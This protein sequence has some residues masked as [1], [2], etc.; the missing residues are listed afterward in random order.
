MKQHYLIGLA[1]GLFLVSMTGVAGATIITEVEAN[2]TLATAQN[3]DSFFS[4]ESNTDIFNSTINPWVSINATGDGSYD[5]FSFTVAAGVTG[6]FDIDRGMNST[7]TEIALWDFNGV[8]LEERDDRSDYQSWT[9]PGTVHH[10]DPSISYTFDTAGTY[11]IGV[12]EFYSRALSGGW[13]GNVLDSGDTYT[14]QVSLTSHDMDPVP[15][16][17]TMLLFGTGLLGLVGYNRKRF[18]KKN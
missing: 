14:L 17:A 11:V 7:D 6:Y 4:M 10:Y 18:T 13:S 12:A 5:Y 3:V 16:P 15:E 1:T 9:D 8:V 2:D